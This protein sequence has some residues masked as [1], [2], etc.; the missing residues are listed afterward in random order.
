MAEVKTNGQPPPTPEQ[1][2]QQGPTL[3]QTAAVAAQLNALKG[4]IRQVIGVMMRGLLVSAPGIAPHMIL[5]TI[6][7]EMGNLMAEA[8]QA[9]IASTVQLRKLF[10]DSFA[11]GVRKAPLVQPVH[12]A[13]PLNLNAGGKG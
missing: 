12:Q 4:P 13:S 8:L 7:W 11:D 3:E 9:D 1:L 5:T 2:A 6:A 10:L